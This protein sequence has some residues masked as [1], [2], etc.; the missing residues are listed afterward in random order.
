[1]KDSGIRSGG[2]TLTEPLVIQEGSTP[3]LKK[4]EKCGKETKLEICPFLPVR[5]FGETDCQTLELCPSCK[6]NFDNFIL[7][8]ENKVVEWYLEKYNIVLA[9]DEGYYLYASVKWTFQK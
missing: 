2:I 4:C 9:P 3:P 7:Q 8:E 6:T 1:M 5:L